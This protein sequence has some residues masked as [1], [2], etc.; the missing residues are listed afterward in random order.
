[1]F[2]VGM[3]AAFFFPADTV[4]CLYT[5]SVVGD[6]LCHSLMVLL[7]NLYLL[8]GLSH[9]NN[10]SLVYLKLNK[11]FVKLHDYVK[12][13]GG[14]KECFANEG[15]SKV[16]GRVCDQGVTRL[17]WLTP[18]WP[19]PFCKTSDVSTKG[20]DYKIATDIT[21][22]NKGTALLSPPRGE[23]GISYWHLARLWISWRLL[24]LQRAFQEFAGLSQIGNLI[25]SR[26]WGVKE[27]QIA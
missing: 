20:G 15:I 18:C 26:P 6:W 23:T 19:N 5:K 8:W 7:Q 25:I 17:V 21:W 2:L 9:W 1:M 22:S 12:R 3:S 16:D 4:Y 27:S 10:I 14:I 13:Y 11:Q 24:G